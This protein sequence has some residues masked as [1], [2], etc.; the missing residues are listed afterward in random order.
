MLK[1]SNALY[2]LDNGYDLEKKG[3]EQRNNLSKYFHIF[4]EVIFFFN[5]QHEI[6]NKHNYFGLEM[7]PFLSSPVIV[8]VCVCVSVIQFP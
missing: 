6:S 8:I 4:I 7:V 5:W 1:V 2:S 3:G